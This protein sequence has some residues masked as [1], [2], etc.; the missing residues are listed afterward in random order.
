CLSPQSEKL[1]ELG[2]R[3]VAEA[4]ALI[5]AGKNAKLILRKIPYKGEV[6]VSIAS[7]GD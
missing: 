1:K 2:I 3:N 6:T 7:I 5:S 4:C